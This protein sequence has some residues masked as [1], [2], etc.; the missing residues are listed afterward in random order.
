MI[1]RALHLS[2][3]YDAQKYIGANCSI[4]ILILKIRIVDEYKD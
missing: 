3:Y 1:D 4:L 2:L